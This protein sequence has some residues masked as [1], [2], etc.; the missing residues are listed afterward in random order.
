M[1]ATVNPKIPEKALKFG[2]VFTEYDA[3]FAS[4]KVFYST[5]LLCNE[6]VLKAWEF[7]R[8]SITQLQA[9]I[10]RRETVQQVPTDRRRHFQGTFSIVPESP[11]IE[12]TVGQS[13]RNRLEIRRMVDFVEK[14]ARV[15]EDSEI[16]G[17]L[18]K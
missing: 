3:S 16:A 8:S 12:F 7:T 6:Y 11:E 4:G 18:R 5:R 13:F 17:F 15:I 10:D 2:K 9:P 14:L 1:I